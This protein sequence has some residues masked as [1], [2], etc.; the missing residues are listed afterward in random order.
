MKKRKALRYLF[1]FAGAEKL[2]LFALLLI[3]ATPVIGSGQVRQEWVA[4]YNGTGYDLD[5]ATAIA[6]DPNGNVYVT[7]GSYSGYATV[8]YDSDGNQLWVARYNGLG[9]GSHVATAIAVDTDGNVYVTGSSPSATDYDYATVKYDCDGNQLWVARY[10]G[11]ANGFNYPTAIAVDPNGN[12]YVTGYSWGGATYGDYATVKYDS[13]GNQLWVARYNGPGNGN[14]SAQAIALDSG[15]KV[16][17]T[18]YSPS[19]PAT[20]GGY[21]TVKYDA[22]GNPLW[23]ARYNGPG[24]LADAARA[25]AL[26]PGGNVYVTGVSCGVGPFSCRRND[27]ATVKYDSDGNQLWVARYNGSSSS[28]DSGASAIALDSAGN[29]YVTGESSSQYATV[30]YDSDGNQLWVANGN[31]GDGVARAM[32]LDHGGNVY[33]TGFSRGGG[34]DF[35]YVT[36]KYDP[37]GNQLWMAR[38]NGPPNLHDFAQGIALDPD[39]NVYVT[40]QSCTYFEEVCYGSDFATVKYAEEQLSGPLDSGER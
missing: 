33:V 17:V 36:V 15:G 27:Y 20:V 11:P 34:T 40:G 2:L 26:D 14:D 32:A 3:L 24:N 37:D 35:D 23:V 38:Y 5:Y 18:G 10:N 16:Y 1:S 21:A 28:G 13:E 12:V 39:G 6:V 22:D 9:V 8:K 31:F 29:V 30:K 7:G 19:G 25:I 4:N